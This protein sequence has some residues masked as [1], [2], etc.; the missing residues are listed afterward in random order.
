VS[1][2]L[3]CR[4][5]AVG[6]AIVSDPYVLEGEGTVVPVEMQMLGWSIPAERIAGRTVVFAVHGFNVSYA[7]GVQTLAQ[8]ERALNLGP[9][10]VFV[11]VLWPGDY[12]IPVVNYPAEAGDAVRCGQL[13]ARFVNE[14][15]RAAAAVSFLSHSL[16][17][18]VVLEAVTHLERR[19]R[20]VCLTAPAVDDDC[21]GTAQ[22]SAARANADRVSVLA[23]TS[24]KV[25]RLAYPVGDFIS[26]VLYDHD[27]PWRLALGYHG[28]RPLGLDHVAPAQIPAAQGYDHGDYFST[29]SR[30]TRSERFMSEALQ[31][32]PHAWPP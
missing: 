11:G 12:W 21:L 25:L 22:Y 15:L 5:G 3:N 18:R 1:L 9:G 2:Y 14:R 24:D 4:T 17:G 23:S 8:V 32:L 13:V 31:G 6:G 30:A 16:G 29:T 20:E 7:A 27:S 19:A 28:P 26:D 10:Y